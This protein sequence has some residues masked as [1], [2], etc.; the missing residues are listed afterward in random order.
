[1]SKKNIIFLGDKLIVYID[2]IFIE[3]LIMNY[4][5]L[6]QTSK[7]IKERLNKF[8][9]LVSSLVGTL[10]VT[11]M[12]LMKIEILNYS[13]LKFVLSIVM[14]YICFTP[15]EIRKYIKEVIVF[16]FIS[17]VNIGTYLMIITLFNISLSNS[18]IKITVY[19]I[20]TIIVWC[21]N[22]QMWRI[23]KLNL[24]KENLIYDVFVPSKGR[25]IAYKG[26]IDTGNTS[27]HLETGRMIFYAN[28]KNICLEEY[29]MVDI[30]V[31]TVNNVDNLKGYIVNNVI[32]KNKNDIK[33][34]DIV[35]CFS[36]NNI[37]NKLGYDM[38]M[39]YEIYEDML[40][41]IYI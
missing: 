12:Y 25:Y 7:F 18:V 3:N 13:V 41:G 10:Y 21:I 4:L 15:K 33:F 36:K 14:V 5:L 1:M 22:S 40:G 35:M 26:F 29:E 20:G 23:F 8:K 9:I 32:V 2:Y 30:N 28:R 19:L 38:I 17:I 39:N 37:K 31:N 34:V 27:K 16:Y 6:Y 11:I 24:K